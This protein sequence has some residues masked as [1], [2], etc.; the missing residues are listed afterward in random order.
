MKFRGWDEVIA[1][2][3]TRTSESVQ[4]RGVDLKVLCCQ[5]NISSMV[6]LYV[7]VQVIM[8]R[9]KI[10]TDLSALFMPRQPTMGL[11]EAVSSSCSSSH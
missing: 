9:D 1:V 11:E 2:D 10:K 3:F 6:S 4:R 5:L 7:H 8:E